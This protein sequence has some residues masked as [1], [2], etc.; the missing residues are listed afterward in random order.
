RNY[1]QYEIDLAMLI[2]ELGGGAAVHGM[3]HSIFALP[4]RNTIQ[5]Y[6]RQLQLVPS[7]SGLQFSDIS[8]ILRLYLPLIPVGRKCG[9]TLSLDELAA[10]PRIDYIPET[11]EMGGLC[12]EHISELETV[13]VGKDLRAV[14]AAV[15]AVKAGKVH[16]SH[17]VCVGAIS[18]LYGTNYGVKPIYMGPT[19][20]KGPWQDGVRLI[21]VIIAAWKR[22]PDGEAKHGPLMSVS[23]D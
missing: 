4:S 19:C 11:D 21:E 13:T 10:D 9:H 6:R 17:E 3:N 7:I 5:T 22:S 23:T 15:T 1:T 14:E 12:L 20:K 8:R 18:H 16:I 2:Y